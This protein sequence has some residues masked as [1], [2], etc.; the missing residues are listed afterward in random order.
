WDVIN[1]PWQRKASGAISDHA[2]GGESFSKRRV[3]LPPFWG[4]TS[5]PGRGGA[6][7]P[8]RRVAAGLSGSIRV[9][10]FGEPTGHRRRHKRGD[11]PSH[12]GHFLDDAGTQKRVFLLWREEN[13][14]QPRL[15]AAV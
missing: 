12:T 5:D 9:V 6:V 10:F 15:E 1:F 13:G 3:I 7:Y 11:I 4:T 8:T 2:F 14:F